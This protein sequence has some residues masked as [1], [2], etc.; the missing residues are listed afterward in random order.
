[1]Y[2]FSLMYVHNSPNSFSSGLT[3]FR[4]NSGEVEIWPLTLPVFPGNPS[5]PWQRSWTLNIIPNQP[6]MALNKVEVASHII[7]NQ[8]FKALTKVEGSK[9]RWPQTTQHPNGGLCR[10]SRN[11]TSQ[12]NHT[13]PTRLLTSNLAPNQ[14]FLRLS[15][16]FTQQYVLHQGSIRTDSIPRPGRL[17]EEQELDLAPR[18]VSVLL[19]HLVNFLGHT[20]SLRWGLILL[21]PET[22]HCHKEIQQISQGTNYSHHVKKNPKSG[23]QINISWYNSRGGHDRQS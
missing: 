12:S 10:Q 21:R 22:S 3:Y 6:F 19:Q 13:E 4:A 17:T 1:M 23:H 15:F 8:L 11:F 14:R 5:W 16:D 7:P 9:R 2:S 20:G 18:P